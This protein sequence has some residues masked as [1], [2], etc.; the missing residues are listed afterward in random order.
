MRRWLSFFAAILYYITF[1]FL[2]LDALNLSIGPFF[3]GGDVHGIARGLGVNHCE[4]QLVFFIVLLFN[5]ELV[6][7]KLIPVFNIQ[8]D[9]PVFKPW[10]RLP[11]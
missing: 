4:I 10:L 8:V 11:I 9:N 5:R 7:Q 3:Y 2:V 1:L 6:A